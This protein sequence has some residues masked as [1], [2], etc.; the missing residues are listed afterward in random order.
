MLVSVIVVTYHRDTFLQSTIASIYT[1]EDVPGPFELIVIDNGGGDARVPPCPRDDLSVRVITSERNLGVAGGRNLGMQLANGRFLVFID[2]DAVWH[3]R[4]DMARLISRLADNPGC[5]CVA[6]KVID[7][8]TGQVDHRL[9]PAPDKARL[10]RG[11]GPSETPYFYGCAY[12]ARA[13]AISVAGMYPERLIYGMEELD[14]SLR[15]VEHGYSIVFDPAIA[16]LHYSARSG[17]DFVGA[18]YWKQQALNKSRVAWRQLP[19][20]YPLTIGLIWSAAVLVKTRRPRVVAGIW[21]TLWSERSLLR[22]E[23]RVVSP[24][25]L[26]YLRGVGARLLY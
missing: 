15:L 25:T 19:M 11:D 24:K 14:L 12:A 23:R 26:R 1:Q 21:S 10:L 4:H 8:H 2:D 6:V 5:G 7:A 16:V 3:D 22:A 18:R 17:R 9:L 20:P 13:D